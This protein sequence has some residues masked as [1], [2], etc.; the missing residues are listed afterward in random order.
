MTLGRPI[1]SSSFLF[2]REAVAQGF[3]SRE[4][5][6]ALLSTIAV[7]E[8]L[9]HLEKIKIDDAVAEQDLHGLSTA[10]ASDDGRSEID[11][12]RPRHVREHGIP[13]DWDREEFIE[14]DKERRRLRAV[15][16]RPEDVPAVVALVAH[17]TL[18]P[19][20]RL[21]GRIIDWTFSS[22]EVTPTQLLVFLSLSP[23]SI[24]R[25]HIEH[26]GFSSFMHRRSEP[27]HDALIACSNLERLELHLDRLTARADVVHPGWI[28]LGSRLS[29]STTL[30][31]L[32]L[33]LGHVQPLAMDFLS[34]FSS[35]THLELNVEKDRSEDSPGMKPFP[36]GSP[37]PV[38]PVDS[39]PPTPFSLPNLKFLSLCSPNVAA[40]VEILDTISTPYLLSLTL[41]FGLA[42]RNTNA[43]S[44]DIEALISLLSTSTSYPSL[45]RLTLDGRD[46]FPSSAAASFRAALE[47]HAS[48]LPPFLFLDSRRA[49]YAEGHSEGDVTRARRVG[50]W[51][52]RKA[53]EA[54][55]TGD[56]GLAR[57]LEKG[58]EDVARFMR[59]MEQA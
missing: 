31:M 29:S 52:V 55:R 14:M 13:D 8:T 46:I 25:L 43:A 36:L 16:P 53:D 32:V 39:N 17:P 15:P 49:A 1:L 47:A 33:H 24:R 45:R 5:H 22:Q 27:L 30:K 58:T 35:I 57:L 2:Y 37:A 38:R 18:A 4:R 56:T 41:S 7:L 28:N 21:A 9:P 44:S 50:E 59:K 23:S 40:A 6:H 42:W 54:E 10:L 19:L 11:D 34:R 12:P 3:S 51:L 20:V 48:A 26:R